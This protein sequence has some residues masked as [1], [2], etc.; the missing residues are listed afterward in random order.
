MSRQWWKF[1]NRKPIGE[2]VFVNHGWQSKA[3]DGSKS[4]WSV[5][6]SI[7]SPICLSISQLSH[8]RQIGQFSYISSLSVKLV[9][10]EKAA[11]G[12]VSQPVSQ[13]GR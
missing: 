8:V 4:G 3:T 2:L 1:H 11:V 12:S 9:K 10:I 6:Q 7:C 13:L 5:A